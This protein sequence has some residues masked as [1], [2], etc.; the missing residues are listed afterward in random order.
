MFVFSKH[1]L[2]IRQNF[3]VEWSCNFWPLQ[4]TRISVKPPVS[5]DSNHISILHLR[6]LDWL[7]PLFHHKTILDLFL[8]PIWYVKWPQCLTGSGSPDVSFAVESVFHLFRF[9]TSDG[10]SRCWYLQ[11]SPARDIILS[12]VI[13]DYY[14]PDWGNPGLK[15]ACMVEDWAHNLS[16]IWPLS[17]FYNTLYEARH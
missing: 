16:C 9:W 11:K 17:H 2:K 6:F 13:T 15:I 5:F 14:Y 3:I 1:D 7:K 4:L 12:L 8:P 10:L